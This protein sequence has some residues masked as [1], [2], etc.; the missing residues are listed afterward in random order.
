M[1]IFKETW[2]KLCDVIS[3]D[4]QIYDFNSYYICGPMWMQKL[5]H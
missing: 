5:P 3:N 2:V 4:N 1:K